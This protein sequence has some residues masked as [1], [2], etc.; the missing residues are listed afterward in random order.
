MRTTSGS[1]KISLKTEL[2]GT[3]N[4]ELRFSDP[5]ETHSDVKIPVT[6]TVIQGVAPS[7]LP[8]PTPKSSPKP[9]ASNGCKN[10]IKN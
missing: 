5:S 1:W 3:W 4:G 8:S 2:A 7:P 6:F 10:Q 9:T